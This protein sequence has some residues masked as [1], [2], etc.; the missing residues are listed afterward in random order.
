MKTFDEN[1]DLDAL[2]AEAEEVDTYDYQNEE[3]SDDYYSIVLYKLPDG[4]HFRDVIAS[5][6]NSSF[7]AALG[8]EWLDEGDL[9]RWKEG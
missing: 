2:I 5:G 4:R 9:D 6:Y 1:D 3:D 8:A 7:S